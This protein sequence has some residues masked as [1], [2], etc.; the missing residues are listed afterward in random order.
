MLSPNP[1]PAIPPCVVRTPRL[2]GAQTTE[3][4]FVVKLGYTCWQF[5]FRGLF[6]ALS[7]WT[8]SPCIAQFISATCGYTHLVF[9]AGVRNKSNNSGNTQHLAKIATTVP[10]SCV[11]ERTLSRIDAR[12]CA[13]KKNHEQHREQVQPQAAAGAGKSSLTEDRTSRSWSISG[14][15]EQWARSAVQAMPTCKRSTRIRGIG[16]KDAVDEAASD[17]SRAHGRGAFRA[18]QARM[19][20][21]PDP[22]R[23]TAVAIPRGLDQNGAGGSTPD[24]DGMPVVAIA[25]SCRGWQPSWAAAMEMPSA[26]RYLAHGGPAGGACQGG[27]DRGRRDRSGRHPFP[28]EIFDIIDID[29][30]ARGRKHV[31]DFFAVAKGKRQCR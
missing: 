1:I 26:G 19:A 9:S 25:F 21:N 16:G 13:Q 14:A 17:S 15:A 29:S 2:H 7:T 23:G 20:S 3:E 5:V 18:G 8:L 4:T 22:G 31:L 27:E 12:A 28:A 6:R 10:T 11:P 24:S 30:N